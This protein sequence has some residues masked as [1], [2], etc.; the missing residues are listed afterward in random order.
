MT[1]KLSKSWLTWKLF[2]FMLALHETMYNTTPG[3]YT[4]RQVFDQILSTNLYYVRSI[5]KVLK[6]MKM[7]GVGM[8]QP[9]SIGII[10]GAS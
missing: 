2:C 7:T 1:R 9:E 5:D 6:T 8:V 3:K 10:S 4:D